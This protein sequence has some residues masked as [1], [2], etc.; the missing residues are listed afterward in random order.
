M[1]HREAQTITPGK[2]A[3]VGGGK[4]AGIAAIGVVFEN[5]GI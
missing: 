5:R 4:A 2:F 3:L 1:D